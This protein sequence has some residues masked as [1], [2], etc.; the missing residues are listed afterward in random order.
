LIYPRKFENRANT[1]ACA[2]Q[3]NTMAIAMVPDMEGDQSANSG[4]VD[5]GH[6]SEV[7]NQVMRPVAAHFGLEFRQSGQDQRAGKAQDMR[8]IRQVHDVFDQQRPVFHGTHTTPEV[9]N[10][11][12]FWRGARQ[13]LMGHSFLETPDSILL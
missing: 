3:R 5:I 8:S 10:R 12:K 7:E 13:W 4:G 6:L 11:R 9:G 1:I 2:H